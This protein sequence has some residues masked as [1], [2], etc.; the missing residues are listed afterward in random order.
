MAKVYISHLGSEK[1]LKES[2][3]ALKQASGF[4]R[5]QLAKRFKT[6]TVPE[7]VFVVDDSIQ[8]G[9]KIS[10]ILDEYKAEIP[11]NPENEQGSDE[12]E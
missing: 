6:R 3:E 10:R 7:L 1:N 11:D 5:S 8:N 9:I 12:R 4:I 2:M